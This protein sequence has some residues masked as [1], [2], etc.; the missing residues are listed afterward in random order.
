MEQSVRK[1]EIIEAEI[2]AFSSDGSGIC[3]V[4]GFTVF[5]AGGVL[6]DV[7]EIKIVKV[8]KSFGYGK[9][10]RIISPSEHR[11][12]PECE[13][14][15][16]CG[17]CQLMHIDYDFQLK[18]KKQIV[19]DAIRRIGGFSDVRILDTVGM[20]Y[21]FRYRNKMQF[22]VSENEKGEVVCG[23]FKERTHEVIP[24]GDC[25]TGKAVCEKIIEAVK[26]YMKFAGVEPYN[27]KE[28]KGCV[29]NIFIR[30]VKGGTMVSIVVNH[31]KIPSPELLVKLLLEADRSIT[32][33]MLNIN[34]EKTNLVLG[35]EFRVL[36]GSDTIKDSIGEFEFEI[37]PASF[38]Q[39]N[40][41]QTEILYK[42]AVDFADIKE[43]D[44]VFDL[45]CGT[46][47]ISMFMAKKA[48]KVI[49]VEIVEEAVVNARKNA[50]ENGLCNLHFY[51]GDAGEVIK[52]LYDMGERADVVVFDPPRKGAD[53]VAIETILKM[54]PKRIVYVSCNPAT[55]ARDMKKLYENGGYMPQ[56][57]LPV[58]MFC[59]THHVEAVALLQQLSLPGGK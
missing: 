27:E 31:K 15:S 25:I 6:G 45:Y 26:K 54:N 1:N 17:G 4:N 5:V 44:T 53:D 10:L 8:N 41:K 51:A 47:T 28:H 19:E 22:P 46:G 3:R 59:Q 36:Y 13:V 42:A 56:R 32:G 50:E 30:S 12:E 48:K 39:I 58:D 49:G 20:E 34:S 14:Y 18:M 9:I 37:S 7:L 23:F 43:E 38:Y 55:L 57:V 16:K 21:P 24:V 33:I 29:R 11:R 40:T 52:R 35:K 2:T